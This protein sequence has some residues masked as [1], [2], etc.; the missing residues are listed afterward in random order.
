[1]L[2]WVRERFSGLAMLRDRRVGP[3]GPTMVNQQAVGA[4]A[5]AVTRHVTA[6]SSGLFATS[7]PRQSTVGRVRFAGDSMVAKRRPGVHAR[8][9]E[10]NR[11]PM[12][13]FF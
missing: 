5:L 11:L 3:V 2:K 1:M 4:I 10:K 12:Q 8:W 13:G 7:N 9:K 6:I